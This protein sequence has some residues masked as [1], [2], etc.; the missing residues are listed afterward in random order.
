MA[1]NKPRQSLTIRLGNTTDFVSAVQIYL[2][3]YKWKQKDLAEASG[4]TET[5]ISR[6]FRNDNGR[7]DSFDLTERMVYKIAAGLRLGR[8]GYLALMEIAFPELFD[9]LGQGENPTIL[10]IMLME[11]GKPTL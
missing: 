9:A 2:T 8:Q 6:M 10:N 1:K 3:E 7:G 11:K 5:M 4:M